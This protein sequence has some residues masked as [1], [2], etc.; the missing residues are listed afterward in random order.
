MLLRCRRHQPS[1]GLSSSS[2]S[3]TLPPGKRNSR[4]PLHPGPWRPPFCCAPLNF[5]ILS[6]SYNRIKS[7]LSLG[8]GLVSPRTPSRFI[9]GITCLRISFLFQAGLCGETTIYY[10][11][12]DILGYFHLLAVVSNDA[13]SIRI[14][15][16]VL[17]ICF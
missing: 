17:R 2:Q 14:Q 11:L 4:S 8:D 12:K 9:L 3:D 16:F 1:S 15:V 7:C 5:T 13:M 10:P 6:A